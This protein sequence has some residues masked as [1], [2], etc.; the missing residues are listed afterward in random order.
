MK[1]FHGSISIIDRQLA[2]AGRNHLDFGKG[3]YLTTLENQAIS[4]ASRPLNQAEQSN[5][6]S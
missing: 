2:N 5:L 1:V 3:F 6:H 4:W